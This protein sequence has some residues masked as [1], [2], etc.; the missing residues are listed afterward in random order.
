MPTTAILGAGIIGVSTA[1][2]LSEHEDP[3]SIHLVEPSPE[4][5]SSASGLAG[6]FLAK[7]WFSPAVAALGELSFQLHQQ[8]A[9]SKDGRQKWGYSIST[10]V[11]Y[12]AGAAP[13]DGVPEGREGDKWRANMTSKTVDDLLE[14]V[15]PWLRRAAGDHAE[16]IGEDGTAAQIDPLQLSQFLL[17]ECLDRGVHLHHPAAAISV[18]TDARDELASIRIADTQSSTE[19]DL[20]CTRVIIA[21]GPWSPQVFKTLFRHSQ[22]EIPISSMAGHSLI[23]TSPHLTSQVEN[24]GCHAVYMTTSNNGYKPGILSRVGG[25][26][27]IAGLNSTSIP[28]PEVAGQ[29]KVHEEAIARL[30]K[31]AAELLDAEGEGGQRPAIV[32][33]GLCF[34]PVTPSGQPII[35]RIPDRDLG[36][37][38]RT[39]PGAD[40]GV[41]LAAGHGPWGIS[42]SLGTGMVL[43]E[44]VQGRPV[45]V[46]I[47]NLTL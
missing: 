42:L 4:L 12:A 15:P 21:A 14:K 23:V 28:L 32:R 31:T 11:S 41:Y 40:G 3:S 9:E 24:A 46:D 20:P 13:G 45:S 44:M 30:E 17:Q 22:L 1:Y 26:I 29:Y 34:R 18:R 8:L 37:A 2:Y 16:A 27:Y 36:I 7:D 5:F 47:G 35:S 19:T 6:G 25:H 43:A 39:R 33:K 10:A 38:V